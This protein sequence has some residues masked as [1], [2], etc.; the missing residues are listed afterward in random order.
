MGWSLGSN[1]VDIAGMKKSN[2]GVKL[3]RFVHHFWAWLAGYY[4]IPCPLCGKYIGGHEHSWEKSGCLLTGENRGKVTCY[5]CKDKADELNLKR[6]GRKC[7]E[8]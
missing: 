6:Y 3:P 5:D 2:H 4:W 7:R 1:E 8:I